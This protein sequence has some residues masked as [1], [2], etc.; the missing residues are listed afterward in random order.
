METI[1]LSV[2]DSTIAPAPKWEYYSIEEIKQHKENGFIYAVI[3]TSYDQFMKAHCVVLEKYNEA[4]D[5]YLS[6]D[7]I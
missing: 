5:E 4:I 3:E 7:L 6:E 2:Y 1:A